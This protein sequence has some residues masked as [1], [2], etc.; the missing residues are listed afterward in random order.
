MCKQIYNIIA[1]TK[2]IFFLLI[3]FITL[4]NGS[5]LNKIIKFQKDGNIIILDKK[6]NNITKTHL[7]SPLV[8]I[9]MDESNINFRDNNIFVSENGDFTYTIPEQDISL[10]DISFEEITFI[11]SYINTCFISYPFSTSLEF[12]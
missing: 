4:V 10:I 7:Y 8:Y 9:K 1:N 6:N 2:I 5:D 11:N 3:I 12:R